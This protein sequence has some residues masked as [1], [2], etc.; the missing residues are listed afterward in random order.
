MDDHPSSFEPSRLR[1]DL[2]AVTRLFRRAEEDGRD[3]LF[4]HETYALLKHL[5]VE[6]CPRSL[7]LSKDCLACR[8]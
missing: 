1:L 8:R 2:D 5:G 6:T 3:F 4:E 7:F